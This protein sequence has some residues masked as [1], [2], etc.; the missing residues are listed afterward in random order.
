MSDLL[1]KPLVQVTLVHLYILNTSMVLSD[2]M[3]PDWHT[4]ESN[5]P[6]GAAILW[7]I[8]VRAHYERG[9]TIDD[10]AVSDSHLHANVSTVNWGHGQQQGI[11]GWCAD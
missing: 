5:P 6:L 4:Q 1:L 2:W 8:L 10:G 7:D 3:L 9:L 11:S